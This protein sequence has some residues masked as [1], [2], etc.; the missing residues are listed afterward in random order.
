MKRYGV[1]SNIA[2]AIALIFLAAL[3]NATYT[4]PMKLNRQWAW[5][6]SWF[7]FTFLG[8]AVVPTLIAAAT[9]PGLWAIYPQI[10]AATLMKMA[11]GHTAWS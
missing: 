1:T 11:S 5:E 8:V 3:M 9:V 4:L 6:H 2:E 10:P 7:A